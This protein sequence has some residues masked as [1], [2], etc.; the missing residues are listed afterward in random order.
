MTCRPRPRWRRVAPYCQVAEPSRSTKP[1][2]SCNR[3]GPNRD[4]ETLMAEIIPMIQAE[5]ASLVPFLE[6]MTP[7]QW[8]APTCCDAW[9]VQQLVGHLVAAATITAPHFF[10]GF[11]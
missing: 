7:E 2:R 6:T 5:R 9:N 3:G 10:S 4:P 11:A 8:S 1:S